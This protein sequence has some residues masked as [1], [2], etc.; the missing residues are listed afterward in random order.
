MTL[1]VV[2]GGLIL[3]ALALLAIAWPLLRERP[4]PGQPAA[5]LSQQES[6][7]ADPLLELEAQRDS[8]YQAIKE[9]EFDYRVGKVSEVDYQAFDA[10]LKEQAV[11]VL[12]E[13][14]ALEAVE[15]D[16]ALEARLEA[17]IAALRRNGHAASPGAPAPGPGPHFCPQCGQGVQEG[18]RFCA[19]CGVVLA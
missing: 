8:L 3:L 6:A 19:R 5:D 1:L 11:T 7:P 14:D 18:D 4:E 2:A 16:P 10:Q 15:A 9:L 13:I 17:E 12:R